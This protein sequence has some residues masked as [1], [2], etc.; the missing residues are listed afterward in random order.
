MIG[1]NDWPLWTSPGRQSWRE[2][3]SGGVGRDLRATR[4]QE[5]LETQ[6][7]ISYPAPVS[8]PEKIPDGKLG[9]KFRRTTNIL[10]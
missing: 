7:G 9:L 2:R 10:V 8:L 5:P 6:P 4:T 1:A 3:C